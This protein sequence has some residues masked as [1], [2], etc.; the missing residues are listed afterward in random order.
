MEASTTERLGDRHDLLR[1]LDVS[2][3]APRTLAILSLAG[4]YTAHGRFEGDVL[5]RKVTAAFLQGLRGVRAYRPRSTEIAVLIPGSP[6]GAE[7]V[8]AQAAAALKKLFPQARAVIGFGTVQLP[9]EA[10]NPTQ[11]LR[12]ADSRLPLRTPRERRL[13]PR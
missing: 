4:Y 7:H 2:S 3:N 13:V 12:I 11:A 5:T 1:D 9:A 10:S 6:E 8:L